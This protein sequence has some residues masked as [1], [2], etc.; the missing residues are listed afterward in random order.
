M[1]QIALPTFAFPEPQTMSNA[2]SPAMSNLLI[3]GTNTQAA[4]I[5]DPPKAGNIHIIYSRLGSLSGAGNFDVRVETLSGG[6]PSGTLVATNT[7]ASAVTASANSWMTGTLTADAPVAPG[8]P[9]AIVFLRNTGAYNITGVAANQMSS[10]MPYGSRY[11]GTWTKNAVVPAIVLEY[12]DGSIYEMPGVWAVLNTGTFTYGSGSTPDE[13]GVKFVS[14]PVAMRTFGFWWIGNLTADADMV[15]YDNAGTPQ[16]TLSMA[17]AVR[18]SN[19]IGI[20]RR[21]WTSEFWLTQGQD[22]RLVLKPTSASTVVL[23][24]ADAM[25]AAAMAATPGGVNIID[26]ARTDAGA[27]TDTN[28]RQPMMGLYIDYIDTGSS[29]G[30]IVHPGMTGGMRG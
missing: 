15:L 24:Y 6:D 17:S 5:I 29:G 25:N 3:D 12:D 19:A 1:A 26:T 21:R 20:Q 22:Y 4:A 9:I 8:T 30:I 10:Q 7:S 16:R 18:F 23:P 27:W 14:V 2:S 11:A 28:T 13:H